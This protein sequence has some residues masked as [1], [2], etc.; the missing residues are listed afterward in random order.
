MQLGKLGLD[1]VYDAFPFHFT[2]D[3]AIYKPL[4]SQLLELYEDCHPVTVSPEG[5]G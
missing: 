5:Q 2:G 4:L 1:F 3:K